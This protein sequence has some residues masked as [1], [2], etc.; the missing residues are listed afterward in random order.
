MRFTVLSIYFANQVRSPMKIHIKSKSK[1]KSNSK[2]EIL[3]YS[4]ALCRTAK[5]KDCGRTSVHYAWFLYNHVRI[6]AQFIK[7]A[8]LVEEL[9]RSKLGQ[10]VLLLT[11]KSASLVEELTRSKLGQFVLL[12]TFKSAS[13]VEELTR[14]KLGQFVFV[15]PE[16][17]VP[18]RVTPKAAHF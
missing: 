13:L 17:A 16:R 15:P 14:S 1:S 11:F 6:I 3:L 5:T 18:T 7:S 2:P 8:S 12:L 4:R 10:F 9:T